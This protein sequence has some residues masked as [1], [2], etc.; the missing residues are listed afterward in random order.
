MLHPAL[1]IDSDN[2]GRELRTQLQPWHYS[3]ETHQFGS[4]WVT[5][6]PEVS[7]PRGRNIM[8]V[9]DNSSV[10]QH[11]FFYTTVPVGE[12]TFKELTVPSPIA[13]IY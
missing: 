10:E 2:D 3:P 8:F 1:T 5:T 12:I 6:G 4:E 9:S 7:H 13:G 11:V